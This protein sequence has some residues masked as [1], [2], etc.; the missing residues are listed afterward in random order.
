LKAFHVLAGS[1]RKA[2]NRVRVS[3]QLIQSNSGHTIWAER[4]DREMLDV[5]DLQDEIARSIAKALSIKLTATEEKAIKV[6]PAENPQAYDF[7]LRGRRLFRRGTRKDMESAAEMFQQAISLDPN[8]ALAY[9]GLGHVCGRIH[10]YYDQN[11]KWMEE[12]ME[13][14]EKAMKIEPNLPDALSARAFLHYGHKQYD[15]AIRDAQMAIERKRD[16]EGAYFVL[17]LSLNLSDRLEEAA[18]LVDLAIEFNGDDYNVYVPYHTTCIRLGDIDRA[19]RLHNQLSHVLQRHLEW[20]PENARARVLLSSF[21][22]TSGERESALQELQKAIAYS[23]ND[24][25]TLINAACTYALLGSTKE[26]LATLKKAV[27]NG[28]RHADTIARDP[29]FMSLR[30]EPEFQAILAELSER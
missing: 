26:A 20:A 17:G 12:G 11:P 19:A 24:A 30:N 9:A 29:D 6:K 16:C 14:C 10:R 8:F 13:A 22:A 21:L 25:G 5:F 2:G 15:L 27:A 4:Y 3:A 28:Y 23:P 1:I 7:Y 18:R